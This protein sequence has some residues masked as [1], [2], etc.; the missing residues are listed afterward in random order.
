MIVGRTKPEIYVLRLYQIE[1]EDSVLY[2]VRSLEGK[3]PPNSNVLFPV[4][5]ENEGSTPLSASRPDRQ[6][7]ASLGR[8]GQYSNRQPFRIP[9]G[10]L[11]W[12]RLNV[13]GARTEGHEKSSF[14][15][16]PAKA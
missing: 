7:R 15:D 13:S 9:K 4:V 10:I 2:R 12:E 14:P 5:F 8:Q 3:A 16:H 11:G 1:I 6:T